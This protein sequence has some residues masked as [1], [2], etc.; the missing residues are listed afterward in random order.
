[1]KFNPLSLFPFSLL[2]HNPWTTDLTSLQQEYDYVV[3]GG[4]IAY[5]MVACSFRIS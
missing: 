5:V 2:N 4:G 3:I 1:M